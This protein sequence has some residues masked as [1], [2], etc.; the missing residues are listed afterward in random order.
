MPSEVKRRVFKIGGKTEKSSAIILPA[1]WVRYEGV[2]KGDEVKVLFDGLLIVL[3]PGATEEDEARA[4]AALE[5][6]SGAS[7]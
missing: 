5:G 3:P 6:R 1:P 4:R 7:E 2:G